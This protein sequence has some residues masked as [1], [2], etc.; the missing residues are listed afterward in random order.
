MS[1][2]DLSEEDVNTGSARAKWVLLNYVMGASDGTLPDPV[3]R[4]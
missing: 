4:A 3:V 1:V 2:L